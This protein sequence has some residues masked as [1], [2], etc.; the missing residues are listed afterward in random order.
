MHAHAQFCAQPDPEGWVKDSDDGLLYWVP[1]YCCT[2]PHSPA[3][4]TMP[5]TSQRQSVSLDFEEFAFGPRFYSPNLPF[6]W[7]LCL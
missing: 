3:L 4:L 7:I 6:L 5:L 1:P 2:G